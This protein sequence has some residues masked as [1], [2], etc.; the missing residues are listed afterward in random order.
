MESKLVRWL[1]RI[2][3]CFTL[4]FLHIPIFIVFIYAFN[5][6]IGQKWPIE[7]FTTKWFGVAWHNDLVRSALTNS[8]LVGASATLI[9][10]VLGGTAAFAVHRFAFFG[11][12]AI[13]FALVL[14]I[15][16]P[17]IVTAIALNSAI[18]TFRI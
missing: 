3:S 12:G 1:I 5:N 14:P 17:G 4:L 8:V 6:S 9:A 16:L 11:R 10:L 15:A 13:S 7:D 18:N 2:A